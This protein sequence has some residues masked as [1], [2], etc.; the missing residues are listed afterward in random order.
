[1]VP[2]EVGGRT[3]FQSVVHSSQNTLRHIPGR[4]SLHAQRRD[5]L[6][7]KYRNEIRHLS[8]FRNSVEKVQISLKSDDTNGSF[9]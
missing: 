3:L 8:I 9:T 4:Y 5:N 6:N 2:N 7:L 1:M